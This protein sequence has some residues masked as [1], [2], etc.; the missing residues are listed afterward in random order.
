MDILNE[1]RSKNINLASTSLQPFLKV[2]NL[3]PPFLKV[4]NLAPPFLKVDN[5]APPFLKV[6]KGG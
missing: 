6:D 1:K 2:D 5:L 3:V 4:N